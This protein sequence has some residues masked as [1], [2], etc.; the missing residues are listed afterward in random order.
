M[1]PN[2]LPMTTNGHSSDNEWVDYVDQ[3][4]IYDDED[5]DTRAD[6]V[7]AA[8]G[9]PDELIP[10]HAFTDGSDFEGAEDVFED[11][12]SLLVREETSQV[13]MDA[14]SALLFDIAM[15]APEPRDEDEPVFGAHRAYAGD[16]IEWTGMVG[17]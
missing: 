15:F 16:P 1:H 4:F 13:D 5:G 11:R 2:A 7:F 17:L 8:E 9:Y 6:A 10:A 3:G 12:V 14:L